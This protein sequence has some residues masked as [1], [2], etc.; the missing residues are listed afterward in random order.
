MIPILWA[1]LFSETLIS[2]FIITHCILSTF[3]FFYIDVISKRYATRA[4][5]QI[6]G[7][8]H[9]MPTFSLFIFMTWVGFA[10]LPFTIKFTLEVCI[11]SYLL[12]Y[13]L[14]LFSLTLVGMN[15][16]GL[17]GF[18]RLIFNTLFGAPVL[19]DYIVLDLT[20]REI[21]LCIFLTINLFAV[22]LAT[23]ICL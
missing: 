19:R 17:I 3:F 2:L 7:L 5:S 14:I 22:N 21:I 23:I 18:S 6:T 9:T 20:K 15:I 13:S 12:N 8:V 4:A 10:G 1:D 11:F 16:I